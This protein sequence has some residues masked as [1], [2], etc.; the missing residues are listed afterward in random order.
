MKIIIIQKIY[1]L[2]A[3]G[4][5]DSQISISANSADIFP[6]IYYQLNKAIL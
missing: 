3:Q 6:R 2:K 5:S 4:V 1:E